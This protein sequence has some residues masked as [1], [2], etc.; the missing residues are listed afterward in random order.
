MNFDEQLSGDAKGYLLKNMSA[1]NIAIYSRIRTE[2]NFWI[3][4]DERK[5]LI[6]SIRILVIST[7]II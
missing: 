1:F 2:T 5:I 7:R 6:V 3:K 4:M